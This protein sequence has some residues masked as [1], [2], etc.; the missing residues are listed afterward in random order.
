MAGVFVS[1][2]T[3]VIYFFGLTIGSENRQGRKLVSVVKIK[4]PLLQF[5]FIFMNVEKNI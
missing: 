1:Y 4:T 2:E 5:L 3:T